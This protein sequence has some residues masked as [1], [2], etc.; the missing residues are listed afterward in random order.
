MSHD[1]LFLA[2]DLLGGLGDLTAGFLGLGN[3]FDDT[4]SNGL[5]K[6]DISMRTI[7][8]ILKDPYLSHVTHG[9]SS[10]R[11][12]IGEGLNTHWLGGNHLDNGGIT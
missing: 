2:S 4:D 6:I 3:G 1:P 8:E 5:D 12:V 11:W 7:E 10:Q 9:E